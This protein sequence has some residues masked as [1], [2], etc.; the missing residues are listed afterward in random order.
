[1]K[2]FVFRTIQK[3]GEEFITKWSESIR[4]RTHFGSLARAAKVCY[5]LFAATRRDRVAISAS[6]MSAVR[7][8]YLWVLV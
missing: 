3:S 7:L 4:P 2:S 5:A 8:I 1:V 6:P